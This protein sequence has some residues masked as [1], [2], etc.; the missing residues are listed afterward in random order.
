M[1]KDKASKEPSE[2]DSPKDDTSELMQAREAHYQSHFGPIELSVM[3]SKNRQDP[4]I[5]VYQFAPTE[6][7]PYWTLIT[8]GMSDDRQP[9]L[10]NV[11]DD[12]CPR[13]EIMLY[14][15]EPQGWMFEALKRLAEMPFDNKTFLHWH[16]T[17]PSRKPMTDLP[18]K[19]TT[20]FFLPPFFE[21]EEFDTLKIDGDGVNILW[22]VPIT[23]S[24]REFA[25]KNGG[26]ALE[27]LMVENEL[28]P[29][30]Y[31]P[32]ESLV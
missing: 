8:G 18:S 15:H 4:Q 27:D 25:V 32:R 21:S 16:H 2:I 11:K 30:V 20:S 5:D 7:R 1:A 22:L 24:E 29:I 9:A 14:V 23:D 10:A 19:L 6:E 28:D 13:A 26:Q 17:V 31:E 3:H 12:S